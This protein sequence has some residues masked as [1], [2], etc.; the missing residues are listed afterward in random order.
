M[1]GETGVT[2]GRHAWSF[3]FSGRLSHVMRFP[4]LFFRRIL[5][6]IFFSSATASREFFFGAVMTGINVI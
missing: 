2:S 3:S 5:F 1:L 4:F 6:V